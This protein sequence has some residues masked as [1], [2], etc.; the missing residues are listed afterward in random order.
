MIIRLIRLYPLYWLAM[1]LVLVLAIWQGWVLTLA[2]WYSGVSFSTVTIGAFFRIL[3][4]PSPITWELFPLNF[5]A[6][7]LFFELAA[8]AAF[9]A[10]AK[11]P[12]ARLLMPVVAAS[13]ALL[14]VAVMGGW[15]EFNHGRGAMNAGSTWGSFGAGLSRV[16]F[17][18]F[19][20]VL[21]YQGIR[22]WP[23]RI[24]VPPSILIITLMAIFTVHPHSNRTYELAVTIFIF[25]LIVALGATSKPGKYLT[26]I[27][28]VV[29]LASYGMYVLQY[30]LYVTA[31]A[32]FP[33]WFSLPRVPLVG[34]GN[35][36]IL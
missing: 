8:N 19:A 10:L 22:K 28:S 21:T 15:F 5:P 3:F 26:P 12:S 9:A 29:G 4:L 31:V 30:A 32:L 1:V 17:S 27:C 2:T 7:S 18:F 13:C 14:I 25:P 36:P 35:R 33:Q 20:G 16:A 11:Q 6:W 23:I 24:N 34:I